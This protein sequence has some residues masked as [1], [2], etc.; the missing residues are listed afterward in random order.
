MTRFEVGRDGRTPFQ[1]LWGKVSKINLVEFGEKVHVGFP[2]KSSLDRGRMAP[3]WGQ[4]VWLGIRWGTNELFIYTGDGIKKVRDIMRF[5]ADERWDAAALETIQALPLT[6]KPRGEEGDAAAPGV[7]FGELGEPFD[8]EDFQDDFAVP[9][10][11]YV[12]IT[13]LRKYGFTFGSARCD[14]ARRGNL[15]F[16]K[17]HLMVCRRRV[18]EAMRNYPVDSDLIRRVEERQTQ[19]A[20]RRKA[21][22]AEPAPEEPLAPKSDSGDVQFALPPPGETDVNPDQMDI[23]NIFY[24][25]VTGKRLKPERF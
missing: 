4:G 19:Y 5:P 12:T 6:L 8:A 13:N 22:S 25:D 14:A 3:K 18:V 9:K 16:G 2:T 17:P 21:R 24:D 1:R 10:N 7:V 11:L 20:E 23:S 15:E